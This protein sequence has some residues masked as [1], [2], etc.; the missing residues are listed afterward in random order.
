MFVGTLLLH[1]LHSTP[2][3]EIDLNWISC[4]ANIFDV[5]KSLE[6]VLHGP[7]LYDPKDEENNGRKPNF[8]VVMGQ[9]EC[10][11]R[12]HNGT[13]I[14]CVT[15][16]LG[17]RLLLWIKESDDHN[18]VVC[19]CPLRI[20]NAHRSLPLDL[21]MTLEK[22]HHIDSDQDRLYTQK[23]D[24]CEQVRLRIAK[25]QFGV[26]HTVPS[27]PQAQRRAFSIE[28]QL[29][30]PRPSAAHITVVYEHGLIRI[31][32]STTLSLYARISDALSR[33]DRSARD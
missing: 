27:A 17:L 25:V 15:T 6:L 20:S 11:N 8:Q 30:V 33:S 29:R 13:A 9:S 19:G 3:M 28:Y 26:W 22:V 4:D 18:I 10:A 21:K 1:S 16:G 12:L 31:G 7:D 2:S 5:R 24:Y 23:Q 14:L 32:V